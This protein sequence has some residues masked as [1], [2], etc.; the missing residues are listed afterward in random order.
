ML[1]EPSPARTGGS[2]SGSGLRAKSTGIDAPPAVVAGNSGDSGPHA[3]SQ[4]RKPIYA[5]Y[6]GVFKSANDAET[7]WQDEYCLAKPRLDP[8][9]DSTIEEVSLN[10]KVWI[11]KLYDAIINPNGILDNTTSHH[12]RSYQHFVEK[13]QPQYTP[14][15][16]EAVCNGILV[17]R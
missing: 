7:W 10:R 12:L 4:I 2:D 5:P 3:H 14:K 9:T 6:K 17:S 1:E 16:I 11:K 13:A 15:L 8:S